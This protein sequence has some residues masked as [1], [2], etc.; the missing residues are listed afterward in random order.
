MTM[1]LIFL[2]IISFFGFFYCFFELNLFFLLCLSFRFFGELLITI[3]S[4][5]LSCLL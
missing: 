4:R 2:T 5:M 1:L 3:S